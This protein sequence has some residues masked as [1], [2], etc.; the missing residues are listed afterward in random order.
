M[1]VADELPRLRAGRREAER[2]DDIVE[3]PLELLE[4]VRAGDSLSPLRPR[5]RQAKLA[6]EQAV[7]P[8]DLLLFAQ[9]DAVAQELRAPA[10][11]LARRVVAP[12]DRAL[13]LET[14]VP[15]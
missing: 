5:E 7:H 10:P 13:V 11:V 6:L 1:A 2:V 9:L 3:A 14:A 4:Q 15:F 12:F 8:L